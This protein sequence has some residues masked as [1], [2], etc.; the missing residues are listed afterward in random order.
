MSHETWAY[1]RE[2]EREHISP[3]P[4]PFF[5]RPFRRICCTTTTGSNLGRK[6]EREKRC[7]RGRK[8]FSFPLAPKPPFCH[9]ENNFKW[10]FL[11]LLLGR[12]GGVLFVLRG[13][14]KV[15]LSKCW[16]WKRSFF[17]GEGEKFFRV[18]LC[19][20]DTQQRCGYGA[21]E[22]EEEEEKGEILI[23][24]WMDGNVKMCA[25]R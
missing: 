18:L 24:R 1:V 12:W 11:L 19:S 10:I 17:G 15:S 5:L 25:L 6:G 14:K 3:F 8:T 9:K 22:R 13:E 4:P 7:P 2:R 21:A 23:V 16:K 20:Q